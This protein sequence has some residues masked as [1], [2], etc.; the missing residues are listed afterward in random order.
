LDLILDPSWL[1]QARRGEEGQGSEQS[2]IG[3]ARLAQSGRDG[4]REG[5]RERETRHAS[6]S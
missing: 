5:E 2:K 1:M 6:S 3:V 4:K